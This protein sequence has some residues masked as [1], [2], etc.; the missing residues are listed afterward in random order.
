MSKPKVGFFSFTSC[1]GCQLVVLSMTDKL[2]DLLG[3]VE[4]VNF[5][6]ASSYKG[7][8]YDVAVVEGA[9]STVHEIEEL[10]AIRKK[11]KILIAL[12]ACA[13]IG[14]VNCMKNFA[15]QY[16]IKREV[17]K[18][19]ASNFDSIL[20]QPLDAIV[21]VDYYARGCPP[22]RDGDEFLE[23]VTAILQGKKPYIPNFPVCSQCKM[24]GNVCTF[25]KE[26]P[27][28]CLG[29]V[30]RAGCLAACPTYGNACIGCRGL[31]DNPNLNAH[32]ETMESAGLTTAESIKFY[33]FLNGMME[34]GK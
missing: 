29:P 16:E 19:K 27:I 28:A 33:R 23:I 7:E 26:D 15:N 30:T 32:Q 13:H 12:G 17:Y 9:I 10:V 22:N 11:A 8:D 14:G 3:V 21:K 1:E 25:H 31:V 4:V 18:D 34:V 5:R 2:L 24:Q 20:A 6:E